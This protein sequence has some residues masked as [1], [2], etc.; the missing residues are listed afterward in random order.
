M[1]LDRLV[2]ALIVFGIMLA[3]GLFMFLGLVI[4]FGQYPGIASDTLGSF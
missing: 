3:C 1:H 4:L 2:N